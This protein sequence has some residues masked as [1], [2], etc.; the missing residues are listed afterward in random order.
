MGDLPA[1]V[2]VSQR[3]RRKLLP[4]VDEFRLAARFGRTPVA[5]WALVVVAAVGMFTSSPVSA[6]ADE[7]RHQ[8]TAWYV[9]EHLSTPTVGD[10]PNVTAGPPELV[11]ASLVANPCYQFRTSAGAGCLPP[12][13]TM[14]QVVITRSVMNYPPPYYLVVGL[15]QTLAAGAGNQFAAIGGRV[16]SGLLNLLALLCLGFAVR[17]R[18]PDIWRY[19]LI[20]ATPTAVF[21]WVVVNPS[22]WEVTSAIILAAAL[23]QTLW[24]SDAAHGVTPIRGRSY[25]PVVLAAVA[26]CLA[27]PIGFIWAGGLAVSALLLSPVRP[28]R[29]TVF[30][31][32]KAM[33]PGILVGVLWILTHPNPAGKPTPDWQS[34]PLTAGNLL[35]W[36]AQSIARFPYH[37][38][39]VFGYLGWDTP[40]PDVLYMVCLIAWIVLLSRLAYVDRVSRIAALVGLAGFLVVPSLIEAAFWRD[41]PAWWQGRYTMPFILGFVLLVLLRSG[42]HVRREV[43]VLSGVSLLSLGAMVWLNLMRY[44]FGLG[45]GGFLP[46][47]L[48]SPDVNDPSY[49]VAL[50]AVALLSIAGVAQILAV[51]SARPTSVSGV[52]T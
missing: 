52:V 45:D 26:L 17:R 36:F 18:F 32:F 49:T 9:W 2:S 40:M 28:T 37:L 44:S 24:G 33:V 15:G 20:L 12:L 25:L 11:P 29:P 7:T 5:L 35:S 39:D 43:A 10:S 23:A 16:A 3:A 8:A 50:A 14:G 47:R 27:R 1:V 22:G 34:L 21:Y 13:S 46:L 31:T 19:L 38:R 42:L 6:G 48:D 30:A 51:L 41:W 4:I